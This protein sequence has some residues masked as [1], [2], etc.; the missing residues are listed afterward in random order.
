[1]VEKLTQVWR[2]CQTK[3][4]AMLFENYMQS[5]G[6]RKYDARRKDNSNSYLID[7]SS[8]GWNR[9]QCYYHKSEWK[10]GREDLALVLRKKAGDY[11]IV[12]RRENRA[13]EVDFSGLRHHND[14][15]IQQ[16]IEE[17]RPLFDALFKQ[18]NIS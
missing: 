17:H 10:Y 14:V 2:R 15:L 18:L 8:T 16:V 6:A 13:F 11:F 4:L 1:M 3:Q 9:V 7:A 5:I 12:Q